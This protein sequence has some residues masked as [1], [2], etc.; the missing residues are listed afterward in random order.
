MVA[1][2]AFGDPKR[3]GGLGEAFFQEGVGGEAGAGEGGGAEVGGGLGLEG[4]KPGE[5]KCGE[6]HQFWPCLAPGSLIAG[7][8]GP[9]G[10]R[11]IWGW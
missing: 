11:K 6:S 8:S 7:F 9:D 2:G 3:L 1:A 4:R 10:T 5:F